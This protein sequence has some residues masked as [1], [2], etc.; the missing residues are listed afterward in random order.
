MQRV[1]GAVLLEKAP[2]LGSEVFLRTLA[3][4]DYCTSF[5]LP[6]LEPVGQRCMGFAGHA[7]YAAPPCHGYGVENISW[8]NAV[9]FG[10]DERIE[11]RHIVADYGTVRLLKFHGMEDTGN[12]VVLEYL[13]GTTVHPYGKKLGIETR[14]TDVGYGAHLGQRIILAVPSGLKIHGDNVYSHKNPLG[15][16][17]GESPPSYVY[18]FRLSRYCPNFALSTP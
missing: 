13:H 15:L 12:L 11:T 6:M 8:M 10:E 16:M 14:V 9:D 1:I 4:T 3:V 18:Y 17:G 2:L 7:G 5:F